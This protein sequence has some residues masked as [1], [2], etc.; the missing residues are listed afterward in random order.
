MK[1]LFYISGRG[2]SHKH[3][4]GE[5]LSSQD[6]DYAGI[7]LTNDFLKQDMDL[8]LV[9]IAHELEQHRPDYIVAHSYGAYLMMH[10]CLQVGVIDAKVMLIAPV[11]GKGISVNRMVRPPRANTLKQAFESG[12]YPTPKYLEIHMGEHDPSG[13][14]VAN[15]VAGLI[16]ADKCMIH[17][18]QGHSLEKAVVQYIVKEFIG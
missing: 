8:Q 7:S 3:G 2:G 17:P 4:M 18:H 10:V 16:G 9:A 12:E 15:Y 13:P 14:E 5:Y 1:K 11:F 6:L